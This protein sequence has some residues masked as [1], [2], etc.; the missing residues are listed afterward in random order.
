M[1]TVWVALVTEAVAAFAIAGGAAAWATRRFRTQ[2][3]PAGQEA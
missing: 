3:E 1:A 2:A